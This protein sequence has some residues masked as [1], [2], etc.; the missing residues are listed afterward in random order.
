[1]IS[2]TMP[3][4]SSAPPRLGGVRHCDNYGNDSESTTVLLK[5]TSQYGP[6]IASHWSGGWLDMFIQAQNS[7]IIGVGQN[8]RSR[9]PQLIT[10]WPRPV[11]GQ[12]VSLVTNR[13]WQIRRVGGYVD[14]VLFRSYECT[15]NCSSRRL[16]QLGGT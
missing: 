7:Q 3:T 1:L 2:H 11:K 14:D 10:R 13:L 9:L 5:L 8:G 6:K 16:S 12:R 4:N 15:G